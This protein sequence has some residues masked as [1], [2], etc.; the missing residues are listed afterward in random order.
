ME[1]VTGSGV[2]VH[3]ICRLAFQIRIEGGK[4]LLQILAA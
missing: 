3:G 1:T 2:R 4:R